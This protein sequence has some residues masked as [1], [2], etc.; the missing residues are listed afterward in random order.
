MRVFTKD[1]GNKT[2][3]FEYFRQRLIQERAETLNSL[4]GLRQDLV[5][6]DR[7]GDEVDQSVGL[8]AE[9]QN[10]S[11]SQRL[12]AH[13]IEIDLAL[14]RIEQGV[15]GICEETGESIESG[16]LMAVPWTRLSLEGA[17][18]RES[19]KKVFSRP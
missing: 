8:L 6:L 3:D 10:L 14:S 7:G 12:R 1:M 19:L 17:E 9:N 5:N 13:L 18:I 11:L 16:R 2:P 15:Y 4:L